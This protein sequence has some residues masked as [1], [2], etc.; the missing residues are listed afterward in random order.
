MG[1]TW[2]MPRKLLKND[3]EWS[4]YIRFEN[5]QFKFDWWRPCW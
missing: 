2:S 1:K 4:K 5:W 3:W